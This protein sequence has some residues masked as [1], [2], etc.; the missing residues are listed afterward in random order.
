MR[1]DDRL[2]GWA[3]VLVQVILLV[4]LVVTPGDD[5]WPTPDW[6][7]VVG[8][9]AVIAGLA[10]VAVAGFGLGK[11]LTPTPVPKATGELRTDGFYRVVRHPIYSGVILIVVGLV[12]GSGS[13]WA[14]LLGV[15]TV[16][17]FHRKA[18]WEET[19]LTARYIDYPDYASVTPRFFP[20]LTRRTRP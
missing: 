11:A 4:G 14:L 5:H 18:A 8:S 16:A 19:K 12:V 2:V 20:K 15:V 17:F 1:G 10:L 6:V 3:F 13:W 7:T 9:I